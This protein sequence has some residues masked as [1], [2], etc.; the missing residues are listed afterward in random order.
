MSGNGRGA[1]RPQSRP[2]F[3][4]IGL[5]VA[6]GILGFNYW[7]LSSANVT[8]GATNIDLQDQIRILTSKRLN[9]EQ[10]KK[11]VERKYGLL[12]QRISAKDSEI[13]GLQDDVEIKK[14]AQE[15]AERVENE[16]TT[17]LQACET[18]ISGMQQ[19]L[20]AVSSQ[21]DEFKKKQDQPQ[22]C[23]SQ[24]KEETKKLYSAM[25][26]KVGAQVMQ[27]I[28][29]TGIDVGDDLKIQVQQAASNAKQIKPPNQN[30]E[31]QKK[32]EGN[33]NAT[34]PE[35]KKN[36]ANPK[37]DDKNKEGDT[38][39]TGDV[40]KVDDK[41]KEI[42]GG[43]NTQDG[44]TVITVTGAP[45]LKPLQDIDQQADKDDKPVKDDGYEDDD[46][47]EGNNENGNDQVEGNRNLKFMPHPKD[48]KL[49]EDS[50]DALRK[51]L[52]N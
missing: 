17:N 26:D 48:K 16:C 25:F 42:K 43:N 49:D 34:Q 44:K 8:L 46:A 39:K 24:C 5:L 18:N 14:A 1:Q 20:A 30:T 15:K 21:L 37:T 3:L 38:Q 9:E 2:P 23:D 32:T 29:N 45:Q 50:I 35:T 47:E 52:N 27:H 7:N 12:E 13:K 36:D 51:R 40:S 33:K 41:N 4:V 28:I 11:Q 6:L 31:Q 22:N 10:S 19:Q